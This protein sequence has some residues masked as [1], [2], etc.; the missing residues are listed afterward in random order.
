MMSQVTTTHKSSSISFL[1]TTTL[2]LLEIVTLIFVFETLRSKR[3]LVWLNR[4]FRLLFLCASTSN[5]DVFS[6]RRQLN[7]TAPSVSLVF[8]LTVKV[9]K[10]ATLTGQLGETSSVLCDWYAVATLGRLAYARRPRSAAQWSGAQG[11]VVC[12]QQ[13]SGQSA[14]TLNQPPVRLRSRTALPAAH[15]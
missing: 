4:S 8:V 9:P 1:S 14:A 13:T 6:R 12:S 5:S 15:W 3:K 10:C 7:S 2:Q 11:P